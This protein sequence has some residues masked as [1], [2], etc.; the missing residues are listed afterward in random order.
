M[1]LRDVTLAVEAGRL[2]AVLGGRGAGKSTLIRVASGTLPADKGDV[3]VDGQPMVGVSDTKLS[4]VLAL[5]VGLVGRDGPD[6][7]LDVA[8]YVEMRLAATRD[9]SSGQRRRKVR[10]TLREFDL[11]GTE[12]LMWGELS[13]WQRVAVELVQ[14]AIVRPRLLLVDDV[15]DGLPRACKNTALE[16]LEGFARDIGCG[17]SRWRCPITPPR[18]AASRCS[19]SPRGNCASCTPTPTSS[20]CRTAAHPA[21][22]PVGTR[23]SRSPSSSALEVG[24][25]PVCAVDGVS[26]RIE[27][28]E[29]V[30]LYGPSGSG[31]STLIDLIAGFQA[32]DSG[33]VTVDGRDVHR[34]ADGAHAD[35]LRLTIGIIGNPE[36]QM[37]SASARENACL[38]L[39]RDHPKKLRR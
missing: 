36:D 22:Q 6:A 8:G 4:E 2:V 26:L 32:P 24:D 15:L 37:E 27:P 18:A 28:G 39:L 34:M 25:E 19:S 3:F 12:R 9:Y 21:G 38:K 1:V 11:A 10:E 29:L 7:K 23:C 33:S 5:K 30:A 20:T 16:W 13:D 35:Y 17:V 31:K 14:A